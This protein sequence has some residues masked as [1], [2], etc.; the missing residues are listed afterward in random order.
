MGIVLFI[1]GVVLATA[2]IITFFPIR[3]DPLSGTSF[4]V[5]WLTSELAGQLFVLNAALVVVVCIEGATSS[6]LGR[7]GLGLDLLGAVLLVVLIIE[8]R[9][10]ARQVVVRSLASIPGFPVDASDAL[11]HPRWS[12]WWRSAIA[13]PFP[14]GGITS[15]KGVRYAP[16]AGAS[17]TLDI[18]RPA[19]GV[20][21]APVLLYVHGGA[22]VIGDKREQGKPMMFE[23]VKRGWVCV[24]INYRL[25][26]KATWPE[27]IIDVKTAI[28]WTKEHI[29][30]FG[31]DPDFLAIAGGSAGGHL[32]SL[33]ALSA[34]D[35]AFQPGF[36][37]ADTSVD[38]CVS[39]YGVLD[40]T[41][42]PA[43]S[44]IH[45]PGLKILLERQV[46]KVPI[47]SN[48]SLFE[49]ASPQ[50]RV[51]RDAPPFLVLAGTND[52]LVPVAVPRAFVPALREISEAP[53]GYVELPLAQHA[54]DV[55][56]SPRCSATTAGVVAFLEAVRTH[57]SARP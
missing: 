50:H 56:A 10:R 20:E 18:Y 19:G 41:A 45:G 33:A 35:P 13:I 31:G 39:L 53:V 52:T 6:V 28:V 42:D 12:R 49:Q 24:S 55:M 46:M 44:G 2:T 11:E 40:M 34:G 9:V 38:A 3:R 15:T 23:L 29:A 1:I 27:H 54:F 30:E 14:G 47:E 22:W 21:G 4:V 43:T 48:R 17:H 8:G 32:V 5:G 57:A 25:S 37:G 7:V 26:P 16:E 51:R 36:E